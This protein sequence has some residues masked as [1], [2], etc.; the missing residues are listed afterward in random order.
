MLNQ[1]IVR[2]AT[3]LTRAGQLVE[4]TA[5][6]Q[7]MLEGGSAPRPESHSASQA[8]LPRLD[9]LTIDA[10]ANEVEEREAPQIFPARSARRRRSLPLDGMR[11]FSR[12]GLRS[13]ITRAPL[14]HRTSC[15]RA[16][17]LSPVPSVTPREAGL[18][19]CSSQAAVRDNR[20]P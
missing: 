12:L 11:D 13:P 9:P 14:S 20:F 4:A 19:S 15:P 7:R 18:T 8:R 16:H 1:D 17:D 6:L 3:R 10:T 5:L 2:E